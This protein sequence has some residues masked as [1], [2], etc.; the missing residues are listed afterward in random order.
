MNT[1]IVS[2][3]Q[4]DRGAK[5]PLHDRKA[6]VVVLAGDAAPY[7]AGI[8]RRLAHR[9]EGAPH[10]VY[11]PGNRDFFGSEIDET[12]VRLADECREVGIELLD[13]SMVRIG[14]VRL[15]GATLWT[16]LLLAGIANRERTH[17][18]LGRF[19]PDFQGKI[20][21]GRRSFT[22]SESVRRHEEDR[23]FIERELEDAKRAGETAVVVTHHAPSP[24]SMPPWRRADAI[25]GLY[26]SG[27]DDLIARYQPRLWIHGSPYGPVDEWAGATRLV[28][29]PATRVVGS[30]CG[31]P[32]RSLDIETET[33]KNSVPQI[34][35]HRSEVMAA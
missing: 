5:I 4:L 10:I 8:V 31:E 11:V 20:R 23:S 17:Q 9:W 24:L 3:L 33:S 21:H 25:G 7:N 6:D 26:A 32:S 12:R 27:L 35:V 1:Q 2:D 18:L 19:A 13:R 15:I 22:T 30:I 16:D 29:A 14:R 28:A 34:G